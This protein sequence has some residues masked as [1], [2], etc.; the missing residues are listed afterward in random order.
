MK[1]RGLSLGDKPHGYHEETGPGVLG[2]RGSFREEHD[3]F[4]CQH[5]GSIQI[6]R[7]DTPQAWCKRCMGMVCERCAPAGACHP[8]RNPNRQEWLE[9]AENRRL[10]RQII[11]KR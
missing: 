10:L 4:T 3:T 5:C 1:H 2:Q 9:A 8:Q 7:R 11:D 6:V